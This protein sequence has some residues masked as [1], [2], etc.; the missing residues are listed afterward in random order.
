[1]THIDLH[2][3][4]NCSDGALS[5]KQIVD[6][7][8]KNGVLFFSIAD[9]DTVSAYTDEIY[10]YLKNK[11]IVLIPAV[12]IST[13]FKGVG[14]HVL[15]YNIDITNESLIKKL[16]KIQNTRHIYLERVTEKLEELGYSVNFDELNKI[17]TVTK[18]HIALDVVQNEQNAN[19]LISNFGHIPSK[20]EFIEL[21]MNE[22]CPA[23]VKK[24]S[25]TPAEASALIRQAGGKVVLAHPV[26]Y[27]H[28]DGLTERDIEEILSS[29]KADG[30]EAYYIYADRNEVVFDEIKRWKAFAKEHKLLST[31]GSDFHVDD[32]VRPLIGF[33]NM[34][35]EFTNDDMNEV[36]KNLIKEPKTF[37][38]KK[39]QSNIK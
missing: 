18:A 5:P 7:A 9:H 11:N 1:M 17:E 26:A 3:H 23:Y 12:E 38:F 6:E 30:L 8:V 28:E 35:I 31:I 33:A 4:S 24:D 14:I 21:V 29:M 37:S 2:I 15:G 36:I 32:G 13:K 16:Y 27:V 19:L 25:I 22:N 39:K 20:G 34:E 10:N